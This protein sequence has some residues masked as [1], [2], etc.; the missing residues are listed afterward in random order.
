M[1]N[2]S[3]SLHFVLAVLVAA[4]AWV[5][6]SPDA[7]IGTKLLLAILAL[8]ALGAII[9]GTKLAIA[10]IR[11]YRMERAANKN[12]GQH[13]T[14]DWPSAATMTK[15]GLYDPANGI[16]ICAYEGA[17][18]FSGFTHRLSLGGA[19]TSKT[20]GLIVP[21]LC[22][23]G[24]SSDPTLPRSAIV[25]DLKSVLVAMT[26]QM[27][28][29]VFGDTVILLDP[30]GTTGRPS[31]RFNPLQPL[32]DMFNSAN[33]MLRKLFVSDVAEFVEQLLSDPPGGLDKNK[34]FL[35]GARKLM[36]FVTLVL[37]V[38]FPQLAT[39]PHI[40]RTLMNQD[41]LERLLAFGT[42]VDDLD[43]AIADLA[44]DL[45]QTLK[46]SSDHFGDFREQCS[47][48]LAPYMAPSPLADAVSATDFD[49]KILKETNAIVYIVSDPSNQKVFAPWT[50]LMFH[51]AMR[52]L[53]RCQNTVPVA[54][55]MD[56]GTG[57]PVQML[58]NVLAQLREYGLRLDFSAQSEVE[59]ER[60]MGRHML[61]VLEDNCSIH[62]YLGPAGSLS[63]A[64]KISE[65]LGNKT[66]HEIS[67]SISGTRQRRDV[68][69]SVRQFGVPLL[70][71]DEIMALDAK[72]QIVFIRDHGLRGF[73][74]DTLT[75][76]QVPQWWQWL[77]NNP[78]YGSKLPPD[79]RYDINYRR[80]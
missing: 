10:N 78:F 28:E 53:I 71:P 74:G 79:F 7:Y 18:I 32:M 34:F 52:A 69:Q 61:P 38:C 55:I 37:S 75:Y 72:K 5:L 11:T 21:E 51:S 8:S 62:Q 46:T 23:M 24:A 17:P 2:D 77:D 36:R 39:L 41:E 25:A 73:V 29:T 48:A 27:R 42:T 6:Y 3:A 14:A 68:S 33:A 43:G 49:W 4:F 63:L 58:P 40:A 66:E 45:L 67:Y 35:L 13:G 1:T 31:A 20:T 70:R 30:A 15:H 64:R 47:Q 26:A 57:Y 50:G 9:V 54:L 65:R 56:E 16:P 44:N 22:H 19:G 80:K 12:T 59:I 76:N 60:T